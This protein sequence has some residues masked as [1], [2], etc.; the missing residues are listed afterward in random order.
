MNPGLSSLKAYPFE[1][2]KQLT[3]SLQAAAK[4]QINF[5]IGEPKHPTPD[6]IQRALIDAID[7]TNRYP[8]TRGSDELRESISAWLTTRFKLA[9]DAIDPAQNVLPVNGTREALFAVTQCVINPALKQPTVVMPNPFYQIY[10]GAAILAGAKPYFVT[11]EHEHDFSSVPNEVWRHCQLVYVCSPGNPSGT[12]IAQNEYA[13]LLELAERFDFVIVA[14]E[15]YSELYFDE[16]TPPLGLL[17]AANNLGNHEFSRC[18]VMHSLSKRSNAPGLRSGFVAGDAK[19]IEQFFQYRTYHG[20]AMPLHVQQASIAAWRD[21]QH[22][23]DNRQ[24]YR[25]K[26]NAVVPILAK[27]LDL[28]TP[29]AGFYLWPEVGRDD[30]EFCQLAVTQ[31]NV[32]LLP[33]QF[34]ARDIDGKNP[35]QCRVRLALVEKIEQCIEGATRLANI[36]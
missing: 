20:S 36:I 19:L 31:E 23:I 10:E 11:G 1:R 15:C 28:V 22:V 26:F 14:D 9:A 13:K 2:L 33:G 16:R 29:P 27:K 5:S 34:L 6:F 12:V 7:G 35:G 3:S 21:E 30:L 25:D 18:L 17:E 24:L 32:L 8:A 4:Q